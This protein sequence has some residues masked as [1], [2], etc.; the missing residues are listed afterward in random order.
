MQES[1]VVSQAETSLKT[2]SLRKV[3]KECREGGIGKDK[4]LSDRS[5]LVSH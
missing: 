5:N 2:E 3:G 1:W 4:L